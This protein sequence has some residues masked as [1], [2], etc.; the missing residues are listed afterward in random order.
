MA[1]KVWLPLNGNLENKGTSDAIVEAVTTPTYVNGKMNKC[2]SEGKIKIPAEYV[3]QIFNNKHMS[4]CFWYNNNTS[5]TSG[6][7]AICGF[8]GNGEGDSGAIRIWDFFNYSVPGDFHWSMGTLGNGFLS[9]VFPA[10]TWVHVAVTFDG[11]NLYIYLDGVLKVTQ[12]N[13]SSNYTF[14]KSYYISFGK[15]PQK[16]NDFRIYDEC[17]SEKQVK[18]IAKGLVCHFKL[19]GIGANPNLIPYTFTSNSWS[20]NGSTNTWTKIDDY[21]FSIQYT[22]ETISGAAGRYKGINSYFV[23]G[24]TYTFSYEIK[25]NGEYKIKAGFESSANFITTTTEFKR[26][27]CTYTAT[28]TGWKAIVF[29]SDGTNNGLTIGSTITIR[30]LKL[31]EGGVATSWIPSES[32]SLY[33]SL[34]YANNICMDV[35]GNE[36]NA[37]KIGTLNFN[38]DSP[39]YGGSTKFN[40]GYLQQIPSPL[41]IDSDA[42]TISCWLYPTQNSTMALI[43]DRTVVGSG[44]SVFYLGGGIRFDTDSGHQFQSG[45]ITLNTWNFIACVYD[46]NQIIK[47]TYINGVQAG[48]AASIGTLTGIANAF[49][50][51]NS[52]TSGTAGAGNQIYGKLSDFRIYCTA[53]SAR[54]ILTL[55]E[56]SGMIDNKSNIYSYEFKEE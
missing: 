3:S 27:Y 55:Y 36:Y 49:S 5:A 40:S 29:Y 13:R 47:K 35:S 1:L 39:R 54:D 26:Y 33:T 34:E 43:N 19:D 25:G 10:N 45:T 18:E 21:S 2:L 12:T 37:T 52:G 23:E 30:N 11:S 20:S 44:L 24:K 50:I 17:L 6:N 15:T 51:G 42:F 16:L 22:A 31:E 56:N 53:L 32:D 41:N 8:S 28:S 7:H 38:I 4:I 46:K 9:N 48:S 14:D